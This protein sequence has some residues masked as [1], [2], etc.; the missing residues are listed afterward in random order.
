MLYLC[1]MTNGTEIRRRRNAMRFSQDSLAR[2]AGI[3]VNTVKGTEAGTHEP[4]VATLEAIAKALA[5][6]VDDLLTP[7]P[8]RKSA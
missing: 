7:R 3:H 4:S 8:R 1:G 5:C 6:S 2:L